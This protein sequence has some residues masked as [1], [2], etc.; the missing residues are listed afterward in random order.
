MLT[1]NDIISNEIKLEGAPTNDPI[2]AG[3]KT[4]FGISKA[5]NP[6]AWK[7]GAPTEAQARAIYQSKYVDAPGFSKITDP[8]LQVQLI[9]YGINSGSYIAIQKLQ[10]I[11]AVPVDGVLGPATFDALSKSDL[12]KVN[13]DLVVARIKMICKIVQ[14]NPSQLK[15]L[16]GWAMR[17]CEFIS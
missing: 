3:G 1:I 16:G 5:A 10:A 2:D 4:A 8:A 9:D 6:E 7:N 12:H 14:A 11:L 15:Y 17:A 13:N